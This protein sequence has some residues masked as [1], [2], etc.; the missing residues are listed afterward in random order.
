ML[1]VCFVVVEVVVAAA[2]VNLFLRCNNDLLYEFLTGCV[3]IPIEILL[4]F[5]CYTILWADRKFQQFKGSIYSA[6]MQSSVKVILFNFDP[7]ALR[8]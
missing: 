1:T 5:H 8:K 6:P 3:V 2:L 7:F 4:D